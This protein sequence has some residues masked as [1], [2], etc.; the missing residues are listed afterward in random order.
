MT[1]ENLRDK[2]RRETQAAIYC[3]AARLVAARGFDAVT[4]DEICTQVGISK[5]TFFNYCDSKEQAVIGPGPRPL[6]EEERAAFLATPHPELLADLLTLH[7]TI[8][9]DGMGADEDALRR[10]RKEIMHRNHAL[11]AQRSAQ[12]MAALGSLTELTRELLDCEEE[13]AEAITALVSTSMY[14]GHHRWLQRPHANYT[15]LREECA[16]AL[17]HL[18]TTMKEFA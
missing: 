12:M 4:V 17:E 5:R 16:R 2:K 10:H 7:L 15:A 6:S 1:H 13:Q 18:A 3:C 9:I 8:V 14:L 11:A